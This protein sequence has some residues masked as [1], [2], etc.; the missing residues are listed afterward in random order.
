M[1]RSSG[2]GASDPTPLVTT[3]SGDVLAGDRLLVAGEGFFSIYELGADELVIGR[4]E[5][6]DVRIDHRAFSRKH[7][8]LRS[9]PPAT[10]QDLGSTN[11][12]RVAGELRKGGAPLALAAADSF[13][14]GPFSFVVRN[15]QK[16]ELSVQKLSAVGIMNPVV[17]FSVLLPFTSARNRL[18]VVVLKPS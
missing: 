6:C 7:A 17:G 3:T 2:P 14:I 9:G 16:L 12:T 11:G 18:F 15:P 13:H 1:R 5:G 4:G 8:V 10:V